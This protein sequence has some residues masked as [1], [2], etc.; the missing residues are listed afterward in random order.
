MKDEEKE[1]IQRGSE[2]FYQAFLKAKKTDPTLTAAEW[3]TT[4]EAKTAI[5]AMLID[6]GKGGQETKKEYLYNG[7]YI[8]ISKPI[9]INDVLAAIPAGTLLSGAVAVKILFNIEWLS[10]ALFF[11]A[12]IPATLGA[13]TIGL[14]VVVEAASYLK[15]RS[16]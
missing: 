16:Q 12:I 11:L 1:R 9:V 4:R 7:R 15:K 10:M 3:A 2:L 13:L 5:D 14:A 8:W 6:S